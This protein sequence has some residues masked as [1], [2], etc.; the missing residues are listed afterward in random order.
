MFHNYGENVL[1]HINTTNIAKTFLDRIDVDGALI[2]AGEKKR[3][4]REL[5]AEQEAEGF[6]SGVKNFREVVQRKKEE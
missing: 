2:L 3:K 5:I 6:I 4:L 1:Q